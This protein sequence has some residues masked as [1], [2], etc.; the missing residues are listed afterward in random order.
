M[1]GGMHASSHPRPSPLVA[2]LAASLVVAALL[3]LSGAAL[4]QADPAGAVPSDPPAPADA[5]APVEGEPVRLAL[6]GAGH[7]L[8]RLGSDAPAVDFPFDASRPPPPLAVAVLEASFGS[9]P[10]SADG[11]FTARMVDDD[12]GPRVR[13]TGDPDQLRTGAYTVRL[14]LNGDGVEPYEPSVQI[15][16]PAPELRVPDRLSVQRVR[17]LFPTLFGAGRASAEPLIVREVGRFAG[18]SAVRLTQVGP[19]TLGG[20]PEVGAI[21]TAADPPDLPPGGTGTLAYSVTPRHLPPGTLSGTLQLSARELAEPLRIPVEIVT[22][23][24]PIWIV[25]IVLIGVLLGY[26]SRQL[27]GRWRARNDALALAAVER[28][29]LVSLGG[30]ALDG[31]FKTTLDQIRERLDRAIAGR[32]PQ[33]IA[34]AA[35]RARTEREAA[36]AALETRHAALSERFGDVVAQL[37]GR[38]LPPDVAQR[39]D[40]RLDPIRDALLARRTDRA[41][42]LLQALT[43]GAGLTALRSGWRD[44]QL[45]ARQALEAADR[46]GDLSTV[47]PAPAVAALQGLSSEAEFDALFT[48][49]AAAFAA[50]HQH[51]AETWVIVDGAVEELL[52]RLGPDVDPTAAAAIRDLLGRARRALV[53][54][55]S[56]VAALRLLT[57]ELLTALGT[58]IGAARPG[59]DTRA[60]MAERRYRAAVEAVGPAP[61]EEIPESSP[62][63]PDRTLAAPPA[64]GRARPPLEPPPGPAGWQRDLAVARLALAEP[65]PAARFEPPGNWLA[66]ALGSSINAA[67]IALVAYVIY[68]EDF[69]GDGTQIVSTLLWAYGMDLGAEAV[70]AQLRRVNPTGG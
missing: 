55:G 54:A 70:K 62:L 23:V 22:R 16:V 33:A 12:R 68:A 66:E 15:S 24:D 41:E 21:E 48:R 1:L 13:I 49:G 42:G 57:G 5:P 40:G 39:L 37:T 20:R 69:V 67:V 4:A 17:P 2:S 56:P 46:L 43:A 34:D 11:I 59:D 60:L 50:V 47:D 53:R 19:L 44:W 18:L 28:Q 63:N 36:R 27:L 25:L 58:A 52:V 14:R 32:D 30:A 35:A 10:A 3:A 26:V 29:A 7:R 51:V 38:P 8:I 64:V 65:P 45:D 6:Q 31:V 61:G 9:P